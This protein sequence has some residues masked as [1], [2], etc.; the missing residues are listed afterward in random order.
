MSRKFREGLLLHDVGVTDGHRWRFREVYLIRIESSLIDTKPFGPTS[1][2]NRDVFS[3]NIVNAHPHTHTP[4][5]SDKSI[6]NPT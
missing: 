4:R 3:V 1:V 5:T 6:I 2:V